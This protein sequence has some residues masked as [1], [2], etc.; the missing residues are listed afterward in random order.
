MEFDSCNRRYPGV[1]LERGVPRTAHQ[2]E[3]G[4]DTSP[5]KMDKNQIL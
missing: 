2:A 4:G 1:T 5:P 3:A